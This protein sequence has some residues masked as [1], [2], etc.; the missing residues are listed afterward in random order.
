MKVDAQ[1]D[2][3]QR[4]YH[5]NN[6]VAIA[7]RRLIDELL[8]GSNA[9]E[10]AIATHFVF[11]TGFTNLQFVGLSALAKN[12]GDKMFERMLS[13]IQTDEARHAQIGRATLAFVVR[14]DKALA[15][16]LVDKWFWRSWL[17][18]AIVTGFSM[19]YLTPVDQRQA[20]FKEFIHEWVIEQY[21]KSLAELGLEKSFYW[22][23]FLESI[24][25]YHHRVYASAYTYRAS[26][27]F[28]FVVPSPAERAWLAEKYPESWPT[29]AP[30]W[31]R[32]DARWKAGDPGNDFA[33]HGTAIV[34]FCSLCQLVLCGGTAE[35]NAASVLEHDGRKY[36]FC[37]TPCRA[38]FEREPERYARH[39]NVVDRVLAGEAPANLIA[40]VRAY[41]GLDFGDWGKDVFGGDYPWIEREV[42]R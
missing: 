38:L 3:V 2:W 8:L 33:V 13:S 18:F 36:V 6:W 11:E 32:I 16:R 12:V 4:F 35:K 17:L 22:E 26:V 19:D 42:R 10:F 37:S 39:R 23:T 14:H 7:G 21:L 34:A 29:L 5:S 30:I 27:W 25:H 41:F 28:D 9:I 1:F 40:L 24:D 15:Q 20:S 31:S